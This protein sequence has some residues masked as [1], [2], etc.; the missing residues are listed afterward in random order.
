M[1]MLN[2]PMAKMFVVKFRKTLF[3]NSHLRKL[4]E[5]LDDV[6]DEQGK[7]FHQDIKAMEERYQ[8]RWDTHMIAYYC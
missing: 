1:F 5:N 8:G 2:F 3:P 7:R 4:P 6:S